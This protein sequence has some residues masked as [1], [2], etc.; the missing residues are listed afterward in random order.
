MPH[1]HHRR[2]TP[3]AYNTTE[4]G[5]HALLA[6]AR[7]GDTKEVER[8][9]RSKKRSIKE[10]GKGGLTALHLAAANGHKDTAAALIQFGAGAS[11]GT[12]TYTQTH[13]NTYTT[14]TRLETAV[15]LSYAVSV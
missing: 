3:D 15:T 11:P 7:I 12:P 1:Q 2:G 13:T 9:L 10:I 4:E 14:H 8:I 5:E 6:A